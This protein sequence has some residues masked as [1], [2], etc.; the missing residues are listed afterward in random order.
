[1][2]WKIVN[3]KLFSIVNNLNDIINFLK[4]YDLFAFQHRILDR[5][6]S[7]AYK[8]ILFHNSPENLRN[9]LEKNDSRNLKHNLMNSENLIK[10]ILMN[11]F[12]IKRLMLKFATF[13]INRS[14][15]SWAL[16]L[17]DYDKTL[18][19]DGIRNYPKTADHR[20][21]FNFLQNGMPWYAV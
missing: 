21:Y 11:S 2:L 17:A 18:R 7:F 19:S 3:K 1:M 13:N 8:T 20:P 9:K 5:M 6:L 12:V 15:T 10:P 4:K 14:F 16:D